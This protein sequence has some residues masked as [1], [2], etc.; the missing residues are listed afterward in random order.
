MWVLVQ[1]K[2]EAKNQYCA[3]TTNNKGEMLPVGKYHGWLNLYWV[4]EYIIQKVPLTFS[5]VEHPFVI[6]SVYIYIIRDGENR[7][8]RMLFF[9]ST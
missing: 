5:L 1:D 9:F 3:W 8:G 4:C 2:D 7:E 6:L